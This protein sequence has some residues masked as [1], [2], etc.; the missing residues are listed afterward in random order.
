MREIAKWLRVHP[1]HSGSKTPKK[2]SDD[3]LGGAAPQKSPA[4]KL[5][6]LAGKATAAAAAATAGDQPR[7]YRFSMRMTS[8]SRPQR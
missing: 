1:K 2:K 5:A 8:C 4:E 3:S 6:E 7:P